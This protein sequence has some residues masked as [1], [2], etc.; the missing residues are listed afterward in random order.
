MAGIIIEGGS[1]GAAVAQT[2]PYR[3]I[4]PT[5]QAVA[6]AVS[7]ARAP[8]NPSAQVV[9]GNYA[10]N[11]TFYRPWLCYQDMTIDAVQLVKNPVS[12]FT[13]TYGFDFAIY[14]HDETTGWGTGTP[15]AVSS[16]I[17]TM[18]TGTSNKLTVGEWRTFSGGSVTLRAGT[19]YWIAYRCAGVGVAGTAG[20]SIIG[21]GSAANDYGVGV[22]D[23]A[24]QSAVLNGYYFVAGITTFVGQAFPS[25]ATTGNTVQT[26]GLWPAFFFRQT[27]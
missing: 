4:R 26:L 27:G 19:I 9:Q 6:N 24:S 13:G 25:H 7:V 11:D 3:V 20:G 5:G 15:I 12:D 8:Q 23:N 17:L 21:V 18:S 1:G 2:P 10:V 14:A 16:S 22:V